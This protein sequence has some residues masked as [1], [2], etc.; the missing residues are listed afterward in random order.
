MKNVLCV[1]LAVFAVADAGSIAFAASS[2]ATVVAA[3]P[4]VVPPL[5]IAPA[6]P[7]SVFVSPKNQAEGRDPFFPRSD[8]PYLQFNPA[9]P[10]QVVAVKPQADLALKGISGSP[11]QPLAIINNATFASGEENDVMTKAGKMRIRCEEIRMD[12]GVVVVQV[13]GERR[14]LRLAVAK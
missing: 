3:G 5:F 2:N 12:E 7:E 8:R 1:C 14:I 13:G 10:V 9:K 11:E 4:F 6:V